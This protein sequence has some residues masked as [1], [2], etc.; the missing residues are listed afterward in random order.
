MTVR[1]VASLWSQVQEIEKKSLLS[2][3]ERSEIEKRV[4]DGLGRASG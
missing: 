2:R 1:S 3:V 4:T